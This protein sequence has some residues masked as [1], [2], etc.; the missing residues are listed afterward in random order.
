MK[1]ELL[2]ATR[3]ALDIKVSH[4]EALFKVL[5]DRVNQLRNKEVQKANW[6]L[7]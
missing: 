4:I 3:D 5:E 6:V 7:L 1:R 2:V